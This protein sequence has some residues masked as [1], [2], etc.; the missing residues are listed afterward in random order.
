MPSLPYLDVLIGLFLIYTVLSLVCSGLN[1]VVSSLLALRA[2]TLK[3]GLTKLL[4]DPNA[5]LVEALY[6]HPLI[7]SLRRDKLVVLNRSHSDG[8]SAIPPTDFV[9]ALLDT[10]APGGQGRTAADVILAVQGSGALEADTKKLLVALAE[11]TGGDFAQLRARW[12]DW[13]DDSTAALSR[14]YGRQMQFVAIGLAFLVTV[15]LNVNT[16]ALVDGLSGDL[17]LRS[18]LV[19]AAATFVESRSIE[20][21][22]VVAKGPTPAPT[23]S[24]I[25]ASATPPADDPEIERV[26]RAIRTTQEAID[27]IPLPLGWPSDPERSLPALVVRAARSRSTLLGWLLSTI[28]LSM[29]APFWFDLLNRAV[30]FRQ[31]GK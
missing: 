25:P 22:A 24:T 2:R 3:V 17:K 20:G 1:E 5:R 28:A 6:A 13:Y 19:T 31:P 14:W 12:I 15:A 10:L 23:P 8:P 11:G 16:V 18:A 7:K 29:G 21:G 9:D 26:R 27:L 4:N 30:G